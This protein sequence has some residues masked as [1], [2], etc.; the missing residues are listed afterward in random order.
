MKYL[1]LC[2]VVKYEPSLTN[3]EFSEECED[4][5]KKIVEGET[6]TGEVRLVNCLS[7]EHKILVLCCCC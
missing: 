6:E 3:L 5:V 2:L 4:K 1:I 7:R